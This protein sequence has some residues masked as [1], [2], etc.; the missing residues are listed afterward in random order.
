MSELN[1]LPVD[2]E[3]E[4]A[5]RGQSRSAMFYKQSSCLGIHFSMQHL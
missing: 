5:E 4:I 3:Q 1:A 2:C